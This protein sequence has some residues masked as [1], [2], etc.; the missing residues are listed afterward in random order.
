MLG[1]LKISGSNQRQPAE[2]QKKLCLI[3][4]KRTSAE[5]EIQACLTFL[6]LRTEYLQ[7]LVSVIVDCI[8]SSKCYKFQ[9]QQPSLLMGQIG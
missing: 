6:P 7:N 3:F 9:M 1:K 2:T 8:G 4:T 5:I